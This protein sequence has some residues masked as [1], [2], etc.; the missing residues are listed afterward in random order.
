M[1]ASQIKLERIS[2]VKKMMKTYFARS[3]RAQ[4]ANKLPLYTVAKTMLFHAASIFVK[5]EKAALFLKYRAIPRFT[6]YTLRFQQYVF[7]VPDVASA[8]WQIDENLIRGHLKFTADNESPVILDCG[9]NIGITCLFFKN[10]YPR[11]EIT[12]YE[13]DPDIIQYLKKNI[14]E[15]GVNGIE[16]YNLAVWT[17]DGTVEFCQDGADGGS[18]LPVSNHKILVRSI[19]LKDV[20]RKKGHVDMLKIDIEG[21]EV[22]VLHD[23]EPELKR[24][25]NIFVEYHSMIKGTQ[26]LDELLALFKENGFRYYLK[27]LATNDSPLVRSAD[28]RMDMQVNIYATRN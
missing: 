11:A 12:A 9:A 16:M 17:H 3:S 8:L 21:A 19:R 15:N 27:E 6:H 2:L 13:A 5:S 1:R 18:I 26:N 7:S 24:V 23:C 20:I 14:G 4:A 25:H 22:Q 28:S 10:L